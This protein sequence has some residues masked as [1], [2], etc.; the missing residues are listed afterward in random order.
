MCLYVCIC[1]GHPEGDQ[2]RWSQGSAVGRDV[3]A[4]WLITLVNAHMH[5][6]MHINMYMHTCTCIHLHTHVQR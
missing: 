6:Y 5:M 4:D 3:W 1:T 2:G